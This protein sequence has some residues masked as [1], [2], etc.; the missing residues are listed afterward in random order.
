MTD[1]VQSVL[2]Q[3]VASLNVTGLSEE[4]RSWNKL[5]GC[6]LRSDVLFSLTSRCFSTKTMNETLTSGKQKLGKKMGSSDD[7]ELRVL[8]AHDVILM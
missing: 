7:G 5:Q 6:K 3:Q 1:P 2:K 4:K 8:A